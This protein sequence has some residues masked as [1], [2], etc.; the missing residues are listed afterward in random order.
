M[1]GTQT[2]AFHRSP[3]SQVLR[4]AADDRDTTPGNLRRYDR[5]S[6]SELLAIIG[7]AIKEDWMLAGTPEGKLAA[8]QPARSG[9]MWLQRHSRELVRQLATLRAT[10]RNTPLALRS[11]EVSQCVE[12]FVHVGWVPAPLAVAAYVLRHARAC[13]VLSRYIASRRNAA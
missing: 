1:I 12:R 2:A 11:Q 3:T 13:P 10:C 7:N 9:A 5:L 6:R 4:Y 8:T